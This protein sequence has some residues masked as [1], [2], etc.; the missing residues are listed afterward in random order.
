MIEIFTQ[1]AEHAYRTEEG[2]SNPPKP[3]MPLRQMIDE[4]LPEMDI[5]G[6]VDHFIRDHLVPEKDIGAAR[7]QFEKLYDSGVFLFEAILDL[8]S[9]VTV[10]LRLLVWNGTGHVD[11]NTLLA[12][13]EEIQDDQRNR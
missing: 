9:E 6:A 13:E 12:D 3:K 2:C 8:E 11:A 5:V 7:E 4:L 10:G 1:Y